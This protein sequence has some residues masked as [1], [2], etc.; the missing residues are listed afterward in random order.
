MHELHH[1]IDGSTTASLKTIEVENPATEEMIGR[2]PRGTVDDVDRAVHAAAAAFPQWSQ[3]TRARRREV[4]I[5]LRDGLAARQDEIGALIASDVGTP[6]KVATR[7]QAG[8]PQIDLQT[9]I[10]LLEQPEVEERIGNSIVYRRA[11]GV[12][13]AIT[14]WNYPLHQIAAK[15]GPALAAGCT[16]VLKPSEVAPLATH[17]LTEVIAEA[18]LPAGVLNVVHGYGH[19]LG[20][21]LVGHPLVDV[22]SFTGS[23]QVGRHIAGVAAATVKRVTLELGGKS[24]SI[25]LPNADLGVAVKVSMANAYLNG[26]QTCNAWTRLLVHRDVQEEVLER[27]AAVAATFIAGDPMDSG[28]RLGPMVSARQRSRVQEY[29]RAGIDDGARLVT[30][31]LVEDHAATL[32]ETGHYVPATVFGDVDPSSRI[33][34]EEVFGPVLSVIPYDD[35]DHAVRI[36]N[37]TRYGLSGAVWSADQDAALRVARR[38]QTGQVDI[39]G[40][41]FNPKAPFGGVKDSGYGRENGPYAMDEFTT[42]TAIQL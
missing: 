6:I 34:Q 41:A 30:G 5:A 16:V 15:V 42:I 20:D 21:A 39:N 40:A 32:P 28:T 33:A 9:S 13:A 29:V 35:V 11:A 18:G 3:S 24:A 17:V 31:G 37:G 36:A 19:E 26:G 14:P 2:I 10:D 8:L 12:V 22:V 27:A 25:L 38:L 23:P 7:I 1:Y 4:L